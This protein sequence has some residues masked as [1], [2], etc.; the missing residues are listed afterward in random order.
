MITTVV[1]FAAVVFVTHS[2]KL[3]GQPLT[4]QQP[5]A[6]RHAGMVKMTC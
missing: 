6:F 5:S 1:R 2:D 4:W 3:L